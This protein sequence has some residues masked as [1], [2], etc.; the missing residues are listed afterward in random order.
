MEK[1]KT[2]A[3]RRAA[4]RR[5]IARRV[6][7]ARRM[8]SDGE[9]FGWSDEPGRFADDTYLC[10]GCR[11]RRKGEPRRG[12]GMCGAGARAWVYRDRATNRALAVLAR[13]GD[14][15]DGSLDLVLRRFDEPRR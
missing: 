1:P 13:R 12:A 14:L 7:D 11:K 2:R 8:A 9:E 4:T 15:S 10:C 6:R 3:A 5:I